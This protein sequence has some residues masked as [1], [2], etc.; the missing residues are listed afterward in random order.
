LARQPASAAEK[1]REDHGYD[2][3]AADR[4][5]DLDRVWLADVASGRVRQVTSAGW[6]IDQFEWLDGNHL[7]ADATDRPADETWINALYTIT[8][9]TGKLTRFNQPAQPF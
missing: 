3:H 1:E 6:R 4:E 8:L 9:S 5:E 2:G 7:I